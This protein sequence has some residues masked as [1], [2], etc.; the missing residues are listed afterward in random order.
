V[1]RPFANMAVTDVNDTSGIPG[2]KIGK[3]VSF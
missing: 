3:Y 2:E 1:L